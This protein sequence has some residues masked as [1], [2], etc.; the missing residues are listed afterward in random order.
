MIE[1]LKEKCQK[2]ARLILKGYITVNVQ[3]SSYFC[4]IKRPHTRAHFKLFF[5]LFN[6]SRRDSGEVRLNGQPKETLSATWKL[7]ETFTFFFEQVS[8]NI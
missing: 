4:L 5:Y 7:P 3:G 1:F 8:Q 2:R 6:T